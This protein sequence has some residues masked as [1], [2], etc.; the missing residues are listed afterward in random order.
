MFQL[1]DIKKEEEEAEAERRL[2]EEA[3]RDEI[4]LLEKMRND[5]IVRMDQ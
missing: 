4:R 2:R 5:E 1:G 3:I